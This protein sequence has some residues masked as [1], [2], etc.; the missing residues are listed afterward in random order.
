M[1]SRIPGIVQEKDPEYPK[2]PTPMNESMSQW[3]NGDGNQSQWNSFPVRCPRE[4]IETRVHLESLKW[5]QPPLLT[6]SVVH[7]RLQATAPLTNGK[8]HSNSNEA[9]R[10]NGLH[11]RSKTIPKIL[12]FSI[13][14]F[15]DS[16]FQM[17]LFFF[18][19]FIYFLCVVSKLFLLGFCHLQLS[20]FT[21]SAL[22]LSRSISFSL[23]LT[24]LFLPGFTLLQQTF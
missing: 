2:Y 16:R 20:L 9:A 13:S 24:L 15:F 21:F 12:N 23:S 11:E 19:L 14:Q 8:T 17:F 7:S 3:I 6:V 10:E 4:R 22:S 18:N 5:E 1:D